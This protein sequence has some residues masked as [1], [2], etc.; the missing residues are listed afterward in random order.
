MK[1]ELPQMYVKCWGAAIRTESTW[2]HSWM[3]DEP[4][5]KSGMFSIASLGGNSPLAPVSAC[6]LAEQSL[7]YGA[8]WSLGSNKMYSFFDVLYRQRKDDQVYTP[9]CAK[10]FLVNRGGQGGVRNT[11]AAPRAKVCLTG[12]SCGCLGKSESTGT[13]WWVFLSLGLGISW[14]WV[15]YNTIT[16]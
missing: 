14:L 4:K 16:F 6:G 15:F 10:S 5:G 8:T 13:V 9:W 12:S 1:K 7:L 11:R 2:Q 3:L